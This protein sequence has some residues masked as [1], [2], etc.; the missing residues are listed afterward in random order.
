MKT[1]PGII[2]TYTTK[3]AWAVLLLGVLLWVVFIVGILVTR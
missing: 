2:H 1:Q 3:E